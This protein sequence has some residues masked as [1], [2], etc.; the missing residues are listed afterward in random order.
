MKYEKDV[1]EQVSAWP[2]AALGFT[3]LAWLLM[4]LL[5]TFAHG[6]GQSAP[7]GKAFASADE[8]ADALIAAAEKYDLDALKEIFGPDARDIYQTG[9]AVADRET[10][11][12]FASLARTKKEISLDRAKTRAF[13]NVGE[14]DWPFAIPLVKRGGKWYFDAN[15]G[16]QELLYRRIG[17]NELTA[18]QVA[19]GY[20]EA[21]QPGLAGREPHL[22]RDD[23]VLLPLRMV[24]E[25]LALEERAEDLTA[26]NDLNGARTAVGE[27]LGFVEASMKKAVERVN[28]GGP[29][30]NAV[31]VLT[32]LNA[33]ASDKHVAR[34][35]LKPQTVAA[36]L[37]QLREAI[38]LEIALAKFAD[39]RGIKL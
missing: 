8:A 17:E 10:A 22:A 12:T 35:L 34:A 11:S 33:I 23:L 13:L 31:H 7:K 38:A 29:D 14:D 30:P 39:E 21:Q 18:I 2:R 9:E 27:S 26:A 6:Q 28:S 16:R 5:S 32:S 15:A 37:Q 3:L 36:G 4:F 20:V 24:R 19:H 1:K 25:D